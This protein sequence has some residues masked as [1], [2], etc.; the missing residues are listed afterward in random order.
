MISKPS[1]AFA[2]L[3]AS[4]V[5]ARLHYQRNDNDTSFSIEW[6]SCPGEVEEVATGPVQCANIL[7]PFDYT[8]KDNGKTHTLEVIKAPAEEQ[9]ALG[10]II[11][12][13]GGPGAEGLVNM[14]QSAKVYGP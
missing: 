1:I 6:T 3:A 13:F 10:S 4:Q 7:V 9:P 14:A 12:N 5:A 2:A 8:D 11:F